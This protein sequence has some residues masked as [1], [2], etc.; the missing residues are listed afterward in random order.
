MSLPRASPHDFKGG[1]GGVVV[2]F[3]L[4]CLLLVAFP[5][6]VSGVGAAQQVYS[7]G[8][9][10]QS[11]DLLAPG[12]AV[13]KTL[14]EPATGKAVV[15]DVVTF[16]IRI[17]NTGDTDI[18]TLMVTDTYEPAYLMFTSWDVVP[19]GYDIVGGIIT[20]TNSLAPYLPLS[21]TKEISLTLDFL[22]VAPASSV[23]NSVEV[24]GMD[25]NSDPV[26]PESDSSMVEI[27]Q[28]VYL[29]LLFKAYRPPAPDLGTSFKEADKDNVEAGDL[30]VY[31]IELI[32]TGTLA[33]DNVTLVDPVPAQTMHNAIEEGCDYN[34]VE[35]QVEWNGDLGIGESHLCR[36]SVRIDDFA[37]G[38]VVNTAQI[39]AD[40]HPPISREV[41][42][43]IPRWHQGDGTMGLAVYS[44]AV[45]PTNSDVVYAGTKEHGVYKSTNGGVSWQ[46]T[47]LGG[48]M[49][50]GLAIRPGG[51]C[52]VVYA[53]TWGQWVQKTED[54]GVSW[55]RKRNGLGEEYLYALVIDP[56]TPETVYAG[57][58]SQGVSKSTNGGNLWTFA[59][60]GGLE[61]DALMIDPTAPKTIYAGTW[62]NGLH[63]TENGGE[64]W[65]AANTGLGV[66]ARELYAVAVDP[67]NYQTVYVATYQDGIYQSVNRADSWSQDGLPG[68]TAFTVMVDETGQAYLGTDGMGVYRRLGDNLWEP[69]PAQPP[70][71]LVIRSLAYRDS[72]LLAGTTNGVWW[73]GPD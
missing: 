51:E 18:T 3:G 17:V 72:I 25:E 31:S 56:D 52:P 65:A 8:T 64:P 1:I 38:I 66:N 37:E 67:T 40:H 5:L 60:L 24:Q 28:R 33:A 70:D 71:A 27:W 36:F 63:K 39:E 15:G 53:T 19:D 61:V 21:P 69:M 55:T 9:S 45:C 12:I 57:T 6:V 34:A 35:Q 23:L 30:L 10:L 42:T 4:L 43:P 50:W 11:S 46:P 13:T 48:E 59:G 26:G 44:L 2:A 62:G 49:V 41:V 47:A 7:A 32:N 68:Q 20:W 54:G 73:Y 29:P 16:T 22:T 14:V 58:Y